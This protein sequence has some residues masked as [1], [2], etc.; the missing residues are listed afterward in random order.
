MPFNLRLIRIA[1]LAILACLAM[2]TVGIVATGAD[3]NKSTKRSTRSCKPPSYPGVGYFLEIR[4]TRISCSYARKFVVRYYRCR[5]RSSKSGTCPRRLSRSRLSR[6][7]CSER[8]NAIST[9]IN[10]TVTCR[11]GS[12]RIIHSY[13][14]NL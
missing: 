12:S 8:R 13:Q 5:T 7:R 9:Q 4:A 14:Q 2:V 11:R 6:F 10:S 1:P 3:A